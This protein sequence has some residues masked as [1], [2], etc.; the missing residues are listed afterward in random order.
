MLKTEEIISQFENACKSQ[1]KFAKTL[2]ERI[3]YVDPQRIISINDNFEYDEILNDNKMKALEE[4]V[5]KNGWTNQNPQTF[6]LMMLPNG[7]L[8][9]NGG[10][11]HRAV[12]S[13]KLQI[14][15]VKASVCI[16]EYY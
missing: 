12:L 8:L 2:P 11:N 16:V 6:C 3:M 13:K 9:V 14:P 5:N 1:G 10:G 7:D 4:S 15:E